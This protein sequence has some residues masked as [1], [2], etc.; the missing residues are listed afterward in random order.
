MVER[1]TIEAPSPIDMK[2]P[3]SSNK[4]QYTLTELGTDTQ[5]RRVHSLRKLAYI[6]GISI[7]LALHYI[8]FA[9]CYEDRKGNAYLIKYHEWD[10]DGFWVTY[11]RNP[12]NL[13]SFRTIQSI[14]PR[15]REDEWLLAQH[16][17]HIRNK[18]RINIDYSNDYVYED[19]DESDDEDDGEEEDEIDE[20][21]YDRIMN[22]Y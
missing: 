7:R 21:E 18:G 2:Y 11:E 8:Y 5:P 16:G 13:D 14:Y 12:P 20:E 4:T 19:Y 1:R 6:L 17:D 22:G 15:W 9:G 10:D 3:P